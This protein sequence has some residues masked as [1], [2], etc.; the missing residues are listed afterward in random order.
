MIVFE[1]TKVL[2]KIIRYEIAAFCL[3]TCRRSLLC[4]VYPHTEIRHIHII[5]RPKKHVQVVI[6]LLGSGSL[7]G[8]IF[9][10]AF[11]LRKHRANRI[12]QFLK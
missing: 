1:V 2:R 12:F 3:C 4:V 7:A 6:A 5:Y 9:A 11:F 8:A 10:A